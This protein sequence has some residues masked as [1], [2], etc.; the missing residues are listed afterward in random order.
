MRKR[1]MQATK[2]SIL[3]A[4]T[5]LFAAEGYTETGI[6]AI[7]QKAG[8]DPALIFRYFDSKENLYRKVLENTAQKMSLDE[9]SDLDRS[10]WP[11]YLA[12]MMIRSDSDIAAL[13]YVRAA[14]SS[15]T[16]SIFQEVIDQAFINPLAK[17]IGENGYM[18]ATMI[19]SVSIGF[20]TQ[21][22]LLNNGVINDAE[23]DSLIGE[24]LDIMRFILK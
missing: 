12:D 1:N 10:E 14:A 18:K 21:V 19:N 9:L 8:C 11:K 3:Q 24:F 16:A 2:E 4:A 13:L 7:A 23:M 6:R 5:T 15:T 17:M 20:S 22:I